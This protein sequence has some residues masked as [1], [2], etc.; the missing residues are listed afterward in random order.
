MVDNK[1]AAPTSVDNEVKAPT[2]NDDDAGMR[3][4]L[5]EFAEGRARQAVKALASPGERQRTEHTLRKFAK[6]M[7]ANPRRVKRFLNIYGILRSARTLEGIFISNDTL[8]LWTI[9]MVRW[10][11]IVDHLKKYP[12]AVAGLVEPLWCSEYF[13]AHLREI[14]LSS[15]IRRVVTCTD[16]GPLTPELIRR[17]CGSPAD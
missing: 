1:P 3:T 12:E 10:P 2:S 11:S 16:G 6:F 5:R 9:L 7:G 4:R 15:E 14:A 13:P 8:A 17:C